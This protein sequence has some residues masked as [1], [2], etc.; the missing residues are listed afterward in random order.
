MLN[1]WWSL[2]TGEADR[3]KQ[4]RRPFSTANCHSIVACE[5]YRMQI[6]RELGKKVTEIQNA[7][8]GEHK[9]RELNDEINKLI[10]EKGHW[11]RRIL[12]LGGPN[13]LHSTPEIGG[14]DSGREVEFGGPGYKYFGAARE[15]PGVKDLFHQ[16]AEQKEKSRA[17]LY[18]SV[19]ADYYGFRDEEDGVL[20]PL[21]KEAEKQARA[22]AIEEWKKQNGEPGDV[23]GMEYDQEVTAANVFIVPGKEEIEHLLLEKRKA[24]MLSRYAA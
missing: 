14:R 17:E 19:D 16:P 18:K 21:E 15:L 9:L 4:R 20:E 7:S 12:E 23:S 5:R 24:D 3:P 11:E 22:K 8:L 6:L 2:K 13:Y 10:R 1:R